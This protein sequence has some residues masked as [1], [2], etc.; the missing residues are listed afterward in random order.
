LDRK[1][2]ILGERKE[3]ILEKEEKYVEG[4]S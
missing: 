1:E 2:K 4:R 3:K